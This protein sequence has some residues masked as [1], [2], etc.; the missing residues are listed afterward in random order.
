M[1]AP[2]EFHG[3]GQA[4]WLDS[5]S[6][7]LI[8][9]GRL[10]GLITSGAAYG[11][12]SNPAIF[13]QAIEKE[14]GDYQAP[15]ARLADAGKSAFEIYDELTRKDITEAADLFRPLHQTDPLDGWISLEVAPSL[16][17]DEEGTVVEA[18][19]LH[20]LLGRA[21]VLIKVPA[22]TAG[23]RAMETLISEG[24]SVNATLM[25]NRRHYREV[26]AAYVKGLRTLVSRAEPGTKLGAIQSVASFF[27]SRVDSLVDRLLEE[28]IASASGGRK[29]L[30]EGLRGKAGLSNC[31]VVYQDF[32]AAFGEPFQDLAALGGLVQRPLWAST[33]TK[34]PAYSDLLYVENL[35][36]PSTVNTIPDKT[37]EALLDH[38]RCPGDTVLE[39]VG[40][41][42][43]SLELL[44]GE[45][46]DVETLGEQLQSE[47]VELFQTSYDRLLATIERRRIEVLQDMVRTRKIVTVS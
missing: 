1:S 4:I 35:I 10:D 15:L 46:I 28:K 20:R 8:H 31:K 14:E 7:K 43:R 47:G 19:R 32:L 34:N 30:L 45:G 18:R 44:R 9:S 22:T 17:A 29:S 5:L 6:A 26:A 38:G 21:N 13:Q 11:V 25:F 12:T 42:E 23:C 41:S 16:S 36:G 3:R 40:E 39:G 37:L 2:V 24:I 33:G 27:V